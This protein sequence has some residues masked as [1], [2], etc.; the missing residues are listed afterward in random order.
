MKQVFIFAAALFC[1]LLSACGGGVA[2]DTEMAPPEITREN[3][4]AATA[5]ARAAGTCLT[6]APVLIPENNGAL[7]SGKSRISRHMLFHRP[8]FAILRNGA[9]VTVNYRAGARTVHDHLDW[10]NQSAV[11]AAVVPGDTIKIIKVKNSKSGFFPDDEY[12]VIRD[13]ATVQINA[14]SRAPEG[15]KNEDRYLAAT[16]A[17]CASQTA[18]QFSA[19]PEGAYKYITDGGYSFHDNR[20]GLIDETRALRLGGFLFAYDS[21]TQNIK[22]EHRFSVSPGRI[23]LHVDSGYQRRAGNTGFFYGQFSAAHQLP[24]HADLFLRASAGEVSS[25]IYRN[26]RLYGAAA[27]LRFRNFLRHDGSYFFRI[28]RPFAQKTAWRILAAARIGEKN[29]FFRLDFYRNLNNNGGGAR[30]FYRREF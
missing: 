15:L 8:D 28:G 22:A 6:Y 9:T 26:S 18:G 7:F 27:E 25:D 23:S 4:A 19:A 20:R 12:T 16:V 30:V 2:P 14:Y 21:E 10:F 1:V 17:G 13:I 3:V 11:R 5:A 24:P 29:N